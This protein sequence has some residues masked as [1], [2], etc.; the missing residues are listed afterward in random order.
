LDSR[1]AAEDV[2]AA[3]FQRAMNAIDNYSYRGLPVLA[4]LY[5]IARNLVREKQKDN[6][7]HRATS[8]KEHRSH[9]AKGNR[10]PDAFGPIDLDAT[11]AVATRI[12]LQEAM[13][14]LTRV[15]REVLLLRYFA[16]LS[17]RE[18]GQ[19]L[20]RSEMAVFALQARALIALRRRL[21]KS[22]GI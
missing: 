11:E 16:G 4:W 9:D 10:R 13:G 7:K 2:A 12:D 3:T 1:E 5:G 18:T 6:V 21:A 17:A 8:L 15:Q 22:V 19:V 20:G 14:H